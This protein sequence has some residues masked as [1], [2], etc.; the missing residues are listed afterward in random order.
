M[1]DAKLDAF[2]AKLVAEVL[3]G[4]EG[5]GNPLNRRELRRI[6]RPLAKRFQNLNER[7]TLLVDKIERLE[8]LHPEKPEPVSKKWRFSWSWRLGR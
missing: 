5:V 3:D 8:K 2:T 1:I 6:L 7:L 4:R